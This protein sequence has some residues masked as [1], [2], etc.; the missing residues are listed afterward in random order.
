[1]AFLRYMGGF[2]WRSPSLIPGPLGIPGDPWGSLIP[3]WWRSPSLIPG[4]LHRITA[5]CLPWKHR[6]SGR[7]LFQHRL[8]ERFCFILN[9]FLPVLLRYA[10]HKAL[11]R[12]KVSGIMMW[13]VF[14]EVII[15]ISLASIYYLIH[16]QNY[17]KFFLVM[18]TLWDLFS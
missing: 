7:Q 5:L 13:H 17:I 8:W 11:Y 2:W 18:R 1:M 3:L 9:F 14:H 16:V 10:W 4:P 6:C 15:I 12:F